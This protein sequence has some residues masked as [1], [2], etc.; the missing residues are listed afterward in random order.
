MSI[1]QELLQQMGDLHQ[2]MHRLFND[3]LRAQGASLAQLKLLMLVDRAGSIRSTEIADALAQ[4]PRTVTE[5]VD[6][7]ERD[8]LVVRSPDPNDRRAKRISL[9]EAGSMIIRDVAPHRDTF[10]AEFFTALS[11]SDMAEY[12]RILRALNDRIVEMGAPSSLGDR[13]GSEGGSG[14]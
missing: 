1:E 8:G 3:R 7:L 5:A 4:A 12:L 9:T 11:A 6:G 2:R 13:P 14:Q 10:A